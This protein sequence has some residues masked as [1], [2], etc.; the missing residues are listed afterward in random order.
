KTRCDSIDRIAERLNLT[1]GA[2]Y[3]H[4]SSKK[5]LLIACYRLQA[6]RVADAL[7]TVVETDNPLDDALQLCEAFIDFVVSHRKHTMPLQEVITVLGWDTWRELDNHYTMG[8]LS[9]TVTRLQEGGLVK[10]YPHSLL[11][12]MIYGLLVEAAINLASSA[13]QYNAQEMKALIADFL[14]GVQK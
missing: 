9:R 13:G 8:T 14:K 2:V 4:F 5:M 11:T 6:Q 3:H 10:D 7:S 1:K 12:D